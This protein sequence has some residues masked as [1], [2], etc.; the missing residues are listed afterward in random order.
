M[1][2]FPFIRITGGCILALFALAS[3][4]QSQVG[5]RV[6]H[7]IRV[8]L[9]DEA[10]M[11]HGKG[12]FRYVNRSNTQLQCIYLHLWPEAYSEHNTALSQ[13]LR[14]HGDLSLYYA[15]E[16]ERGSMDSLHFRAEGKNIPFYRDDKH[17]DIGHLLLNDPLNP[18]DSIEVKVDFRVK[19]PDAAFSRMGTEEDAFRITQWYPK[20][21]VYDQNGWH[22]M[23]YLKQGEFYNE[24]GSYDVKITLPANYTVGATGKLVGDGKERKRLSRIA[25]K[26]SE[27]D[28]FPEETSFPASSKQMKTLHYRA[29]SVTDFAWFA[30]KRYRV[31]QKKIPL[32]RSERTVMARVFFTDHQA[33]LWKHSM[34]YLERALYYYSLWVGP[35]PHDRISVVSSQSGEGGGMEYPGV[36]VIG[37]VNSGLMLERVIAHE[38]GHNWFQATL[39]TNERRHPWMDEGLNSYYE[40]RYMETVHPDLGPFAGVLPKAIIEYLG[41]EDKDPMYQHYL[42][43]KL[44]AA[45]EGDQAISLPA[46]SFTSSN[47]GAMVYSKGA[48]LFDYLE[49]YLGRETVDRAVRSY[50]DEERFSHPEPADLKRAFTSRTEK[51]LSP[52][53]QG[54]LHTTGEIDMKMKKAGKSERFR[55]GDRYKV[56]MKNNGDITAP[57][58]LTVIQADTMVEEKWIEGLKDQRTIQLPYH[59]G[60]VK[61]FGVDG[62]EKIPEID[63]RNNRYNNRSP[64][65]PRQEGLSLKP[66][67]GLKDP[68]KDELYLFPSLGWNSNDGFMT[69]IGIH[70]QG[71]IAEPFDI[72]LAPMYGWKS[73]RITGLASFGWNAWWDDSPLL[74]HLRFSVSAKRFSYTDIYGNGGYYERLSPSLEL[75]YEKGDPRSPNRHRTKLEAPAIRTISDKEKENGSALLD[76]TEFYYSIAQHWERSD[77]L[78]PME[79]EIKALH[80]EQFTRISGRWEASF[81]YNEDQDDIT[82]RLFGG[83]FL[84][85][86]HKNP[87]Y[88]WQMNGRDPSQDFLFE[89]YFFG[90]GKRSGVLSQQFTRSEGG[91]YIP[92]AYGSSNEWIASMGLDVELPFPDRP[93]LKL[94]FNQGWAP[95]A[96]SEDPLHL[97]EAGV[98][99]SLFEDI[100]EVHFPVLFS[101]RIEDEHE[102]NGIGPAER[103]RFELRLDRLDL[104]ERLRTHS[105]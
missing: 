19:I 82:L 18:G 98:S 41:I 43:Y 28:S 3:K 25:R 53:F 54:F 10:N 95:S 104:F 62:K 15:S 7:R 91:L 81:S 52:F 76:G 70:D 89:H 71:V 21:A 51:D 14:E 17:P 57:F 6:D 46:T 63:R 86:G 35:Y 105:L 96:F 38:V 47:Y 56:T 20:P 30:D 31:L 48:L 72:A 87:V 65:F 69:G 42:Q 100:A 92:T 29:D 37:P 84:R 55:Y 16:E 80:H 64:L 83:E 93:A 4:G 8:R 12:S 39:A 68:P 73:K 85:N 67:I 40:N 101:S 49:Q 59:T 88:N 33:D 50:Y 22:T 94:F 27:R 99:L 78:L 103:I 60:Q 9:D 102:L 58:P 26:T 11:L 77:P 5:Q 36:S 24:F 90:R 13:Q 97:Y 1:F 34:R 61:A 74:D 75:W 44:I 66:V 32:P 45:Q 79:A 2:R 23:P